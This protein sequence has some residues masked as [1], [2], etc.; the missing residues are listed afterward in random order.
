[1]LG[2]V[3]P[4]SFSKTYLAGKVGRAKVL[5]LVYML[6]K[7]GLPAFAQF[8]MIF[9]TMHQVISWKTLAIGQHFRTRMLQKVGPPNLFYGSMVPQFPRL[10]KLAGPRCSRPRL[11]RSVIR[12]N[13]QSLV[14]DTVESLEC[15][16]IFGA[17]ESAK[18]GVVNFLHKILL[19]IIGKSHSIW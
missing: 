13:P 3:R 16:H 11:S 9:R 5:T 14:R 17:Y 8:Y 12:R 10:F 19:A 18:G 2:K 15:A 1:M 7:L 6:Q 4:V